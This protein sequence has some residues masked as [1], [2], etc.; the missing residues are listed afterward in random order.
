MNSSFKQV[1]LFLST[2]AITVFGYLLV[3][4]ILDSSRVAPITFELYAALLGVIL[5]ALITFALLSKQTQAELNKEESIKFLDLKISVYTELIHQ[6]QDIMTKSEITDIDMIEI[7]L[8][9]QKITYVASVEVLDAFNRFADGFAQKARKERISDKDIDDLL[10]R[11]SDVSLAVREDLLSSREPKEVREKV[12]M[13]LL[14]SNK[15]L[16]LDG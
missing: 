10:L 3:R 13:R 6:V 12:R 4:S 14:S 2:A 7:R 1:I 5:T 8:L 9:N 15:F 16:D 11:L